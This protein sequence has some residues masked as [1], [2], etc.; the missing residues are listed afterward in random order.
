MSKLKTLASDTLIY[1]VSTILVRFLNWML[2]P[3]YIRCMT[4]Q[5][6]G[7]ITYF[8]SIIAI[9]LV[10]LTFGM[11]TGF[12]KFAKSNDYKT[13]LSTTL[14]SVGFVSILFFIIGIIFIHPIQNTLDIYVS[15]G[16]I[17]VNL[18]CLAVDAFTSIIFAKLRY[19]SNT[20]KYLYLRILNVV[21]GLFFTVF[22]LTFCD[23]ILSSHFKFLVSW[24]YSPNNKVYYAFLANL[25]GSLSVLLFIIPDLVFV[26]G[27]INKKLLKQMLVF[28]LPMLG[29]GITGMININLDKLL[30]PKLLKG[31]NSLTDLAVYGA[32]FKIG[33]LMAMFAQSF[34]MAFEPFC[35]KF[36]D[37][38]DIKYVYA[39]VLKYFTIFGIFI[40]L[41]VLFYL[42]FINL[43]L[44]K[45]YLIGNTIIP[46]ILLGQ[47]FSGIFYSQSLW[48]KLSNK[49]IY[50]LYLGVLGA[51]LTISINVF[52]VPIYGYIASA[53]AGLICFVIMVL[54]SFI[55]GH[56][57]F[58]I[59]Y[60]YFNILFYIL[61]GIVL[62]YFS[63][64][65]KDNSLFFKVIFN[66]FLLLVFCCYVYFKEGVHHLI[67]G[68]VNRNT[69]SK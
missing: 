46:I 28:S 49:P 68:Y 36:S 50:G 60:E 33:L 26:K 24:F 34:R 3:Y 42:D 20:R 47:L 38:K 5:D 64:F 30:L 54:V 57:Y 9:L 11:E 31:A 15:K 14:S 8:Y 44:T 17:I 27:F 19:E 7:I 12:F 4:T 35:F 51:I 39:D 65:L 40:F 32:N 37:N 61:I 58:P 18:V 52:F 55:I 41:F 1:G 25:L 69:D 48:Y 29:V 67:L 2:M 13:V 22:Y 56:K 66:T 63:T 21:V 53:W 59:P 45:E 43:F 62:Y 16:L 10:I 6:Y 23:I